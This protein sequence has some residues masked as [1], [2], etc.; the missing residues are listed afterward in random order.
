M[1]FEV[2]DTSCGG[3]ANSTTRAATTV[4]PAAKL[5]IDVVTK[6]ESSLAHERLAA[7]IEAAG[8]HPVVGA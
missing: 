1:E 5:N 4:D 3:C 7:V 8:F 2:N 6:I